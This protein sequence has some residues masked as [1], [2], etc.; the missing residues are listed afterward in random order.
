[1]FVALTH[2]NSDLFIA[3]RGGLAARFD[4]NKISVMGRTARGVR[5]INLRDG[6]RAAGACIIERGDE[7][8]KENFLLVISEN[9]FGKR[10]S[11]DEFDAKG[12]GIQGMLAQKLTDKTGEICGVSIVREDEDI[13]MITNAGTMIRIPADGVPVYGRTA[14][15]VIVMKLAEGANIVNFAVVAKEDEDEKNIVEE[16]AT[17]DLAEDAN[18]E[19]PA[20]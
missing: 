19:N 20:E 7:W 11:A 12:R 17:V 4:E 15:G 6:D 18:D 3:T 2:G 1:M 16:S 9:G 13:L 14:S 10:M 8:A 5:G